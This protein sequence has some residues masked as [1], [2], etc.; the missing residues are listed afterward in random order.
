MILILQTID[1][2]MGRSTNVNEGFILGA[3]EALPD[4]GLYVIRGGE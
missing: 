4:C 1:E 3:L 2:D